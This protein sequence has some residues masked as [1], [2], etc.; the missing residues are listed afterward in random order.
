LLPWA[1]RQGNARNIY[2]A[3]RTVVESTGIPSWNN[4]APRFQGVF[5]VFGDSKTAIK[6]SANRYN[7][8]QTTSIADGFNPIAASTSRLDWTDV[9]GDNIAQ[10]SRYN[11]DG[12][13]TAPC[14]YP[15]VDCEINLSQLNSNFGLISDSGAVYGGFPRSYTFEQSLELQHE[16]MS[17]TGT[18]PMFLE[19]PTRRPSWIW[20]GSR[21]SIAT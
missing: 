6:Y 7:T 21:S 12:S 9:N 5:D 10:G 2:S 17:T 19:A 1:I 16:L 20:T 3:A 14:T 18:S 8:A 11:P 4:W 13:R 15:S